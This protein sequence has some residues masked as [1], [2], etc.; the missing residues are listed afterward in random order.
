MGGYFNWLVGVASLLGFVLTLANQF[1]KHAI[2]R[3]YITIFCFGA[4]AGSFLGG[5]KHIDVA[6]PNNPATFGILLFYVACLVGWG[7]LLIAAIST[8][9]KEKRQHFLQIIGS[10][11]RVLVFVGLIILFG[12]MGFPSLITSGTAPTTTTPCTP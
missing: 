11:F 8:A 7:I 4:L 9:D 2:I 3:N 10:G 1:P 12:Y 6:L 5:I